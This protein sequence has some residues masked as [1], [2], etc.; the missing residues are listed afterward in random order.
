MSWQAPVCRLERTKTSGPGKHISVLP[1][2]VSEAAWLVLEWLDIGLLLWLEDGSRL[3]FKRD[4]VL[5]L[6]TPDLGGALP[7]RAL[8]SD[9]VGFSRRL[10]AS[11]M[12]G[13]E[14]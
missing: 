10:L 1:L 14:A 2:F 3:A 9:A 4:F 11:M 7:Q 6:P 12:D 5:P 13:D 8:Y